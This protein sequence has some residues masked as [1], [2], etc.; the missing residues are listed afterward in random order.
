MR[1]CCRG[2]SSSIPSK[3]LIDSALP[4]CLTDRIAPWREECGVIRSAVPPEWS[5]RTAVTRTR[6]GIMTRKLTLEP[7]S[8]SVES[9]E[10]GEAADLQGTVEAYDLAKVPC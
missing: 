6:G 5:D 2:V 9:F 3:S 4:E 7:E 10:S 1:H 8:L